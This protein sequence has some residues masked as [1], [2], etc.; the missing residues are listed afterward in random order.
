MRCL[1]HALLSAAVALLPVAA[2]AALVTYGSLS[3][4]QADSGATDATGNYAN[5]GQLPGGGAGTFTA[6]AV[7]FTTG[8]STNQLWS[9]TSGLTISDWTALL[10]GNDIAIGGPENLNAKFAAPVFAMG[11][12]IVEPT[13]I[14]VNATFR[15]SSFTVSLLDGATEVGSFGFAP[16]DDVAVFVGVWS[17]VAFD[18]VQIREVI[19]AGMNPLDYSGNEFFGHF[20][21][22]NRAL[23]VSAVPEPGALPLV[24]CALGAAGLGLRRAQRRP[25]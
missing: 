19:P 18:Q 22:G 24:L 17:D 16:A 7:T 23:Q 3:A 6:G 21:A 2:D 9:G 4:F 12:Y 8:P 10:A 11:F 13:S 20:Y 5:L 25:K 14:N 15:E 1:Q